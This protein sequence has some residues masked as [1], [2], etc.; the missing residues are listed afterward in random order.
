[1]DLCARHRTSFERKNASNKRPQLPTIL[2]SDRSVLL[3]S[4]RRHLL[5]SSGFPLALASTAAAL[6]APWRLLGLRCKSGRRFVVVSELFE[7]GSAH[8]GHEGRDPLLE[9]LGRRGSR[10]AVEHSEIGAGEV[11]GRVLGSGRAT[12][13]TPRIG[14][15]VDQAV[16]NVSSDL[17][18]RILVNSCHLREVRSVV[19][20]GL[21]RL[22]VLLT[23][24]GRSRLVKDDH[25]L[26]A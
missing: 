23:R 5:P 3:L 10:A 26:R 19:E 14:R 7:L 6:R 16:Q 1:M 13:G 21:E 12:V 25:E 4:E 11:A 18:S 8:V 15:A 24:S 2:L 22:G 20:E 9:L 17:A